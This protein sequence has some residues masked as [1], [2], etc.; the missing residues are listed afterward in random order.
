[1]KASYVEGL[2]N[3][4][5]PESCGAVREGGDEAL[6]GGRIRSGIEPRN[7]F[8]AAQAAGTPGCRRRGQG[9]SLDHATL[10]RSAALKSGLYDGRV[11]A[12]VP[13]T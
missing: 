4:N 11:F 7:L 2:A 5:G 10:E 1:M 13:F 3:H 8:A 6:T 12:I 9:G